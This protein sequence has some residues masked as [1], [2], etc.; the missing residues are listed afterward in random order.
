VGFGRWQQFFIALE[1][2]FAVCSLQRGD[3]FPRSDDVVMNKADGQ[4]P[5]DPFDYK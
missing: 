5:F 4:T 1:V 3:V 2:Q